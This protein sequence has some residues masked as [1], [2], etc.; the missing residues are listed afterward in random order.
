MST[1]VADGE[2]AVAD[3]DR[4]RLGD[5]GGIREVDVAVPRRREH[6]ARGQDDLQGRA[7]VER[8][9]AV[10]A[11]LR[12][13]QVLELADLVPVL[14]GEVVELGPVDLGV[15]ELPLVVVEVAPAADRRVGRDGLPAVV[16]DRPRAEHRVELRLP[17]RRGRGVVEAV[18]HADAVERALDVALDRRRRLRRRGRR[19]PSGRG[20]S[21]GGTARGSRPRAFMPAGHE[22]MHG[23][24]VPPLNS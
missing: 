5:L 20:R 12:E 8:E 16:P 21:R 19:G 11:G 7:V 10:R 13:P 18:A 6:R 17:C 22:M 4:L 24:L 15:V 9:R 2:R 3:V 23:S 1:S 14:L